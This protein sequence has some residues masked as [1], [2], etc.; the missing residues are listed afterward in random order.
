KGYAVTVLEK[1]RF[2]RDHVGESLLPFCYNLFIELEVLDELT[3]RFVRKPGVRFIDVDGTSSTTWCFNH[4]I[5]DSSYLSF[6][7][8]RAEFDKVLLENSR[9]HGATVREGTRVQ[10][11]DL[12]RPDG[13]VEIRAT[14]VGGGEQ[15]YRARFVLDASGRDTFLGSRMGL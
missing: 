7:V 9:K 14:E 13:L 15:T 6:H 10:K 12:D 8:F 2:P 1:E 4:V 3:K 11:V 5:K